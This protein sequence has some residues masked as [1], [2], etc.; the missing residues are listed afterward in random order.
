MTSSYCLVTDSAGDLL[1]ST[2][3]T[4]GTAAWT[5]AV[6]DATHSLTAISCPSSAFC[7]TGDNAGNVL[8]STDPLG[9]ASAWS[10]SDA[11]GARTV[12]GISCPT[13]SLCV[14]VDSSGYESTWNSTANTWAVA[15]EDTQAGFTGITCPSQVLCLASDS[16]GNVETAT[17]S[18]PA[19]GASAPVVSGVPGVGHALATTTGTFTGTV[20]YYAYQWQE[21]NASG[22]SCANIAGATAPGYTLTSP[23]AGDTVRAVVSAVNTAGEASQDSATTALV[24]APPQAPSPLPAVSGAPA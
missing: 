3:P 14:A 8:T 16:A 7:A 19:V 4:G 17:V 9:G 6:V 18:H 5:K 24:V 15:K 12:T 11:D 21:C 23:S 20:D 13:V 1:T 22:T 2:N 10:P